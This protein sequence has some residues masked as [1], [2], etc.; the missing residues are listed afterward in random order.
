MNLNQMIQD[1]AILTLK[2]IQSFSTNHE[3]SN[4]LSNEDQELFNKAEAFIDSNFK[5]VYIRTRNI[6]GQ[7]A[8]HNTNPVKL[9]LLVETLLS[10]GWSV[11][12]TGT[13]T[14]ELEI[15]NLKYLEFHHNLPI[16]AQFYLASKC[17]ARVMSAEAGLFVAWAAT[18]MS[19]VLIGDEWSVSNLQEPVSL[20][21][22]RQKIS[23]QDMRLPRDFTQDEILSIFIYL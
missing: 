14:I 5:V 20:I 16:A 11:L 8:A 4:S 19:L 21:D 13:P 9:Q 10:M 1:G 17:R 6:D 2:Q 18:E 7:A 12:N 15:D 3:I 23:I 22:S